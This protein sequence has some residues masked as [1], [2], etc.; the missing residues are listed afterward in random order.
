M[1]EADA[2]HLTQQLPGGRGNGTAVARTLASDGTYEPR[3]KVDR[4]PCQFLAGHNVAKDFRRRMGPRISHALPDRGPKR[5]CHL[6][7]P[8]IF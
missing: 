3:G 2:T 8:L 4:I 1:S 6:Y 7:W 5:T